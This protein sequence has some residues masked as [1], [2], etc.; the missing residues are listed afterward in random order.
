M[1]APKKSRIAS[2][3]IDGTRVNVLMTTAMMAM[4]VNATVPSGDI[5]GHLSGELLDPQCA[6]EDRERAW[7]LATFWCVRTSAEAPSSWT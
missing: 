1:S 2:L 6:Q 4:L 7:E 5:Y 3:N